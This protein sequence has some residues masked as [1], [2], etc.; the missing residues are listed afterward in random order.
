MKS[1]SDY[2]IGGVLLFVVS[3]CA[4]VPKE[5]LSPGELRLLGL[6]FPEFGAIKQNVQY[7]VN[8]KFEA[9]GRPEITR[10][11][12]YWGVYGPSCGNVSNV[13]HGTG[14]VTAFVPT[15]MVGTYTFK[16]FVYYLRDGRTVRS[17]MVE[18]PITV[19]P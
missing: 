16:A 1:V 13:N 8:L 7:S 5:P 18:A 4:T 19:A 11:C 3:S 6:E 17:N 14:I 10:A 15:P 9:D 12:V 2:L